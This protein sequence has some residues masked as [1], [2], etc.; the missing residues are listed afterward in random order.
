MKGY[1]G[2]RNVPPSEDM[3]RPIL[4][5]AIVSILVVS[6]LAGVSDTPVHAAL[7]SAA[8]SVPSLNPSSTENQLRSVSVD[9]ATDAWAVGDY[10]DDA[11]GAPN[12]LILHWDGTS[13]S[14]VP[15]PNP[16]SSINSLYDVDAESATDA[17]A[18]GWYGNGPGEPSNTLILHWDGTS[19][20]QMPSPNPGGFGGLLDGVSVL[21]ATDA[22]AVGISYPV[23]GT[24]D[25]LILHWDGT[26]W[27]MV[28]GP[29]VPGLHRVSADSATD[30]WAIAVRSTYILHWDGARWSKVR[31]HSPITN[32]IW[33][34]SSNSP[35]NAWAVGTYSNRAG[36]FDT[37][38]LHW[39][40]H[41]WARID[42]PDE[43]QYLQGVDSTRSRDAWAVGG[44]G[45]GLQTSL[46]YHWDGRSWSWVAAPSLS[47]TFLTLWDVSARSATDAWAVGSYFDE[48]N[49]ADDVLI[50]H[51]D[52]A[53]WSQE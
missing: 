17:W 12:T 37:L 52:G 53:N 47:S 29:N 32:F 9:S 39:D 13:W 5:R 11:T 16:G 20:S 15:S 40:G 35:N 46:I 23:G 48:A 27:S 28:D 21:S 50:L 45:N 8:A 10:T 7:S 44:I 25:A 14:H 51:W 49:G 42:I 34:V 4:A 2:Q 43:G 33:G 26:S 36:H 41:R 1:V 24:K 19:W 3:R 38:I 30:A 22:W 6:A 31:S 18:V